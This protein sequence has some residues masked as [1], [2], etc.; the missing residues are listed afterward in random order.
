M[1]SLLEEQ[2]G[3]SESLVGKAGQATATSDHPG[4]LQALRP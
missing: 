2:L 3:V 1:A 4:L